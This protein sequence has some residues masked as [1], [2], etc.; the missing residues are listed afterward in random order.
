MVDLPDGNQKRRRA[1]PPGRRREGHRSAAQEGPAHR[2]RAHRPADRPGDGFFEL[3]LYAA[4]EMYEEWGGAPAAG[5]VTGLGAC[6][7][8]PGDD[9]RQRRHGESRRV[10]PDDGEESDPRAKHR[11]REPHSHDLSGR[12]RRRF[13]AAAGGCL[14]RHGRF[15]PRLPQQRGDERHGHSADHRD[16]GHV[17]RRAAPI[18]R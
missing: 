10:F 6:R 12:F 5:V 16:H 1:H 11:H 2:P 13:S 17:R 14:P 8:T 9:H 7:R 4:Y 15:R 3:G 18:C